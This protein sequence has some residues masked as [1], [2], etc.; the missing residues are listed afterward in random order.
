MT[1]PSSKRPQFS[2]SGQKNSGRHGS[3]GGSGQKGAS[4]SKGP[5]GQSKDDK[6]DFEGS[7][8]SV[9]FKKKRETGEE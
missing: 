2:N 4:S 7:S 9:S 5:W 1:Q 6:A 3:F 8:K